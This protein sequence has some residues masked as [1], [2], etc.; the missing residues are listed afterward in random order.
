MFLRRAVVFAVAAVVLAATPSLADM[1][2]KLR[3]GRTITIPI[4]P[5]DV[6]SVTFSGNAGA[7][8]PV[9]SN[10]APSVVA[11]VPLANASAAIAAMPVASRAGGA[12]PPANALVFPPMK[13][14]HPSGRVLHVGP[15]RDL[16]V[17]SQ[18]A[19][20][21]KDGDVIEIDAADYRGDVAVWNQND[22]VIRGV[23][24]RPHLY[25]DGD[26]AQGKAIWVTHG[27][28][29]RIANIEFSGCKVADGNGAAIRAE[30]A[31]LTLV[32]V[33]VHDNEDGILSA[34]NPNSDIVIENS[35]FAHNGTT[36][37]STHGIYI[38]NVRNFVLRGSYF[39]D[40]VTGH[41]VKTRALANYI[42]YNR[43]MDYP[44]G[45]ASYSIDVSNGG[46]T[47]VI[48]NVIEKGPRAENY[49][50]IA[51]SME[52]PTNPTQELYV[53]GNTMVMDRSSGLFVRSRSPNAAYVADNVM[54]G[55]GMLIIGAGVFVNNV[56]AGTQA[57]PPL[58]N[59]NGSHGNR[60]VGDVR[61]A[62][63]A[64]YDYHLLPGS[65][66]IGAGADPG[67]AGGFSLRPTYV[68]LMPFGIA[69]R[70]TTGP[71]DD[72]AIPFQPPS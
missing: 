45:T 10:A 30:G 53:V 8:A 43:I 52:G 50:M 57:D 62:D 32:D 41:H 25:A 63:A 67:T 27:N 60:V 13:P 14:D 2:I 19:K 56:L 20:E 26:A 65:P 72:G 1:V 29:I 5:N 7:S 38:G 9:Q 18:A 4:Q 55:P 71:L 54:A 37:G 36:S 39:H 31:G 69:Q 61:F 58:L 33:Y 64:H 24:G 23:G 17:P 47:Y 16:K 66:A 21:A 46:R 6:E 12:H 68:P 51:Y 42:L 40:T 15:T 49:A 44:N 48:G 70:A 35:E 11:P 28:K 3:D 34:P 59:A 22:I